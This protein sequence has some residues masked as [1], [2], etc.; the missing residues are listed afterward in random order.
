MIPLITRYDIEQYRQISKTSGKVSDDI[1]NQSILDA[2]IVDVQP[3]VGSDFFNDILRNVSN[4]QSLLDGGD[5]TYK[6]KTYSN[7][8]LKAVIVFYAYSRY[9]MF[10]STVG[11]QYGF[12]E[13][14]NNESQHIDINM[15]K[16]VSKSNEKIAFNYWQN[17][18]LYLDRNKDL[19]PE[20]KNGCNLNK[21]F[22]ISI[23]E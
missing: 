21:K 1:L 6:N 2:Q 4:Y 19:Y 9:V 5:Y 10:G 3:L 22:R 12:M 14:L 18:K 13:K 8:G 11:T 17:V 23:I 20:Y 7:Y 15:K 16:S